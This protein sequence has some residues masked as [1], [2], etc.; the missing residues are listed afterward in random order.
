VNGPPPDWPLMTAHF[1]RFYGYHPRDLTL[2]Q[3]SDLME[4]M[5]TV[6]KAERGE[7]DHG[8]IARNLAEANQ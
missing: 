5:G 3:F 4:A 8:R 2:R 1:C 7:V 6:A